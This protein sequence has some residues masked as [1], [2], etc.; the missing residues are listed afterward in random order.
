[1]KKNYFEET[2]NWKTSLPKNTAFLLQTHLSD[3]SF[4][5]V[6]KI[7]YQ[8]SYPVTRLEILD[9]RLPVKVVLYG[10]NSF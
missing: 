5:G 8:G 6:Q 3:S 1:M 9:E 4:P 2:A 10:Y 7:R